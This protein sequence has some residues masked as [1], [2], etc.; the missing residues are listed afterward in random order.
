MKIAI[1]ITTPDFA[2]LNI[3]ERLLENYDFI[4][5]NEKFDT[6]NIYEY[7]NIKI[8]TTD[9]RCVHCE[10]FDKEID[11]DLFLFPTTHRSEAGVK[12]LSIHTQGNWG[13]AELGGKDGTLGVAPSFYLKEFF[14]ELNKQGKDLSYEITV[15]CTHHGPEIDKPTVF[16]EIG[17]SEVQWK[18][19]KA[20]LAI[21]R[22]I[23]N[24]LNKKMKSYKSCILVGGGHYN[25]T[26]NEIMLNTEYAVGHICP[27]YVLENIDEKMLK[28]AIEKTIPKPEI[29]I[30][31]WKGL[32]Q[33]KEKVKE[34]L[35][36]VGIKYERYQKLN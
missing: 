2:G 27:K 30:L 14:I 29:V 11:A 32:G 18:D 12:S 8:Y 10:D 13:K 31:D 16:L 33:Y 19:E 36:K 1:I 4:E 20:A 5:L 9:K 6:H 25:Q 26:A 21:A 28:Q 3:K 23:I 35:E 7:K 34:L 24:V 17:T 15:E 22:T